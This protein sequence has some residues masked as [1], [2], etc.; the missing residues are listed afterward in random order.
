M[1]S[2]PHSSHRSVVIIR[3]GP[4]T[5]SCSLAKARMDK[6]CLMTLTSSTDFSSRTAT[7]SSLGRAQLLVPTTTALRGEAMKRMVFCVA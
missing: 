5:S 1:S 4:W 7:R 6:R 2:G 3:K